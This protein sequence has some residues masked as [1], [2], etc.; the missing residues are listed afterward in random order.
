MDIAVFMYKPSQPFTF[1]LKVLSWLDYVTY[2]VLVGKPFTLIYLHTCFL[3]AIQLQVDLGSL[4][5]TVPTDRIVELLGGWGLFKNGFTGELLLRLTYKAY[6][7]DEEDDTTMA[8]SIDT[9][10][11]DD[12]FTDYDETDSSYERGQTDSSNERDKDFMDVLAA[13]LVSEEFQGIVSSETGYN[14]I[15]DDVSSTGSTGLRSRGLRAES[16]P[17]D[18]DGPSAG[19]F[20]SFFKKKILFFVFSSMLVRLNENMWIAGSTL[21]WFAVITIILVLIAINMGGSSFFNP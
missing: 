7:E 14:K 15:F 9:D 12:E 17:S 1:L 10:A 8:E 6:V 16:S 11:S 19:E 5:D 20:R 3:N 21:V 13:L 4:K 2:M 18:S